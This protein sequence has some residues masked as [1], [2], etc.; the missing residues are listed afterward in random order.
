MPFNDGDG[1]IGKKNEPRDRV[2]AAVEVMRHDEWKQKEEIYIKNAVLYIKDKR[3]AKS[4]LP[5][6]GCAAEKKTKVAVKK[7]Q[8]EV[9]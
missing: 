3:G 1:N 4:S 6:K 9:S 7:A 5:S 8:C 2:Q